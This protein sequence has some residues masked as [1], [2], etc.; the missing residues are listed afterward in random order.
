MPRKAFA[1]MDPVPENAT[2]EQ[3]RHACLMR[4]LHDVLSDMDYYFYADKAGVFRGDHDISPDTPDD[5]PL[6]WFV[7]MTPE[8][9]FESG[10]FH[11]SWEDTFYEALF[12]AVDHAEDP[13]LAGWFPESPKQPEQA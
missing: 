12:H 3:I 7:H 13:T 5:T 4:Q 8:G 11:R 9:N 1:V 10:A 2:R 6:R